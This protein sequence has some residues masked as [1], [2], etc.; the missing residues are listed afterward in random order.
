MSGAYTKE[1]YIFSRGQW[2]RVLYYSIPTG[3]RFYGPEGP[4]TSVG[5]IEYDPE[6]DRIYHPVGIL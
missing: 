4:M 3:L 1:L 6:T 2:H 5:Y